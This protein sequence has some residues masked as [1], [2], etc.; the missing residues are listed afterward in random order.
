MKSKEITVYEGECLGP[1]D[2]SF[3]FEAFYKPFYNCSTPG[4]HAECLKRALEILHALEAHPGV[5]E[6]TT[7]GGWPRCGWGEV[8]RVGMYDGWPYWKP[9]PSVCIASWTGG[10]VWSAFANIT[11]I[12][13]KEVRK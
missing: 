13:P 11:D 9:V 7:D 8:L 1:I 12:R 2:W 4:R 6:V 3:D 5:S 10:G